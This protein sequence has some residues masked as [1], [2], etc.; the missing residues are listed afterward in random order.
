[1]NRPGKGLGQIFTK[2]GWVC[3][4]F[5]WAIFFCLPASAEQTFFKPLAPGVYLHQGLPE[6]YTR[7]NHG[8]IS[9]IGLVVGDR[10]AALV[11]SG[12]SPQVGAE[13]LKALRQITA[14]PLCAVILTHMH[15]DHVFGS[16]AL[17]DQHPLWY[18]HQHMPNGLMSRLATYRQR[19][20]EDLGPDQGQPG[21][22]IPDHLVSSTQEIDLGGRK[23]TLQAWPT[24]HTDNDL[25][26][27]D[28]SSGTLFTGDL[29]FREHMPVLD[30]N[31][32][33]WLGVIEELKKL[34]ASQVVPGH[35]P[36]AANVA[37]A[38][39]AEQKYLSDL[40]GAVKQELAQGRHLRQ[41]VDDLAHMPHEDWKLF[42]EI[43]PRNV[44]TAYTELEWD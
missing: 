42:D 23:L 31:L 5:L 17:N 4:C 6:L 9:N 25:T 3:A 43:H 15:L 33:G 12:G 37:D 10:C 18:A 8:D 30:G 20:S 44:T 2:H 11:D 27:L 29:C 26:V 36:V 41:A 16:T 40:K 32:K 28:S 7:Q 35:G 34:S 19:V 21:A 14:L 1:M 13:A 24:A 22:V 38:V 39:A